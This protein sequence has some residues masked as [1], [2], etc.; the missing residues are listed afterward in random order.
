VTLMKRTVTVI[1]IITILA[2]LVVAWLIQNHISQLQNQIDE[3]K[4]QNNEL[5]NQINASKLRITQF[6]ANESYGGMFMDYDFRAKIQ[7]IG[8]TDVDNVLFEVIALNTT[9]TE[10]KWYTEHLGMLRS[11]ETREIAG[12]I[13]ISSFLPSHFQLR[14]TVKWNGMI[15]D[16]Q[17]IP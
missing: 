15:V 5:Q 7:N 13:S 17:T 14:A 3:L 16:D 6:L 8:I 1:G 12:S 10:V 9:G 2:L 11:G 4:V